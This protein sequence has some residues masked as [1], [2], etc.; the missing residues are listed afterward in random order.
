MV[1]LT[2]ESATLKTV[3][4]PPSLTFQDIEKF[5]HRDDRGNGIQHN[6]LPSKSPQEAA[7]ALTRGHYGWKDKNGDGRHDI[8]YEF[9]APPSD[10]K[11]NQFN[12]TGFTAVGDNQREQTRRSMQSIEDVAKVKFTEGPKKA[13]S[14]GHIDI[15]NYGQHVDAKGRSS[16]GS[17]QAE[18]PVPGKSSRTA[19]W[20]VGG[21]ENKQ[22]AD[23]AHGN[24]GRHTITHELNH[25]L[26]LVHP[27]DYDGTLDR[28]N[29]LHHEDSQSHSGMSY[30]GERTG[31]INHEGFRSSAPQ[32]DDITALQKQYGANAETRK[33][34]TTYGFNSNTDRDFLSVKTPEDKM[35]ASIWDGGGNDTLD[36]SGYKQDQ[37]I[38]LKAGTFSDVGGLKGNISIAY[39]ATIENAIGGSGND[40]LVGNEVD[41]TL[42]GGDGNDRLYGAEG[43]DTLWGGKGKDQFVYGKISDSTQLSLDQIMD[44]VSGEDRVDVSGITTSLGKGP[45]KFVD[46]FSGASGEAIVNYDPVLHMSTLQ[47]YGNPGEPTFV[48]MVQGKLQPSDIVS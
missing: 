6:G 18:L 24:A 45:L 36:F 30:R 42:K 33:G 48:L 40:L 7:S 9:R 35:V 22:I 17:S 12:K 25:A 23:A 46:Q 38:T 26:G 4:P 21:K 19:V 47:I 32:L 3:S 39:G 2:D 34:D 37:K 13:S 27:G 41:N 1:A 8:T 43:A 11:K 29:V 20:F 15:G 31:H 5:R 14:D 44:F 10:G 28:K 16:I